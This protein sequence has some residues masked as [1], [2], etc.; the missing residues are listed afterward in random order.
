MNY[1][2]H[3]ALACLLVSLS[4]VTFAQS[5]SV[6]RITVYGSYNAGTHDNP[7]E[8]CRRE[9]SVPNPYVT[10]ANGRPTLLPTPGCYFDETYVPTGVV[11]YDVFRPILIVSQV[12]PFAYGTYSDYTVS[13]ARL[14]CG[15]ADGIVA[16]KPVSCPVKAGNPILCNNGAKLEPTYDD[17]SNAVRLKRNFS[18]IDAF[19]GQTISNIIGNGWHSDLTRKIIITAG[20]GVLGAS[21]MVIRND[22]T[23][24]F[25]A[26]QGNGQ[27]LP[28]ADMVRY[29]LEE[30]QLN[31]LASYVLTSLDNHQEFYDAA[32]HIYQDVQDG[33][34]MVSYQRDS[35]GRVTS[36]QDRN[37]RIATVSY[38]TSGLVDKITLPDGQLI[39]YDYDSSNRLITVTKSGDV[40]TYSYATVSGGSATYLSGVTHNGVPYSMFTYDAQ[41]RANST[42]HAGG[43]DHYDV[44]YSSDGNTATVTTPTGATK[45]LQFNV[46][47]G[48][49][50]PNAWQIAGSG[51]LTSGI[52]FAYNANSNPISQKGDQLLT[53]NYYDASGRYKVATYEFAVAVVATC[54]TTQTAAAAS[55]FLR[56]N[57]TQWDS[58]VNVPTE[59]K[60]F[61]TGNVL[62]ARS[63]FIYNSR[64]Q[65]TAACQID[66]NNTTAMAY[67]CGSTPNA[68]AGVRQSITTYC[69]AA[70]VT[71]GTCP[72]VGLPIANNGPRI[73]VSDIS[74]FNYYQ[75]DD[76]TCATPPATCLYR[77]G[78]LWKVTNALNQTTEYLKY[79][80]AGR[81]LQ[82]KDANSVITDMEYHPRGWLKA[83]KVRGSDNASE[84]DD[85]ITRL[86]YDLSG[87]V[88]KVT[89][90]DLEFINLTYDAAHRLTSISDAWNNSITYSLDNAGKRIAETAA[91]P[92][93]IITLS[94]SNL[95]DSLGRLKSNKNAAGDILSTL[96]YDANDNLNTRMDSLGRVADQDVDPLNRLKKI[97][98]DQGAGK[99]NA[100]TQLFYDARDNLTKVTDPKSLNTTYTYDGLNNLT[101]L[102]SPDT[103][104]TIYTYDEAGNRKTQ[105]DAKLV[106]TNYSYDSL[107]RL[108]QVSYPSSSGLT[109]TF[110]YDTVNPICGATE[111]FAKGR[112]TKFT[113][114][115]GNTQYCFDRFGNIT[116][117]QVTNNSLVS[118]FVY[119]YTLGGRL[120]SLTYP[121]GMKVSYSRN[122]LGQVSQVLVTYGTVTKVFAN[123]ITYYPFGPLSKIEFVPPGG[124]GGT[125]LISGGAF[126]MSGA[127]TPSVGGGGC[128]P[129]GCTPVNPVV[130]TRVY[131]LDYAVQSIGGLQYTV[132]SQGSITQIGDPS[133]N[134]YEYDN[135][136]RLTGVINTDTQAYV[137]QFAY[138]PTGNRSLKKAGAATAVTNTY[139]STSHQL[140]SVGANQRSYDLVGNAILINTGTNSTTKRFTYDA[141][142]RMVN[143]K[144]GALATIKAEYQYNAKGERVR[145]Y[146]G[147]TDKARYQYNENG[148]LLVEDKVISGVTTTQEI[149]WLD[150]MPI[151][152]SQ[153][154]TLHGVLTDHLNS[155]RAIFEVGTQK[156]V[157]RWNLV[158]DAFGENFAIEDADVDGN[159][160]IFDLR[161]PGQL[162][163]AESALH[164][165]YFRDYDAAVGRYVESDPIGLR[166]GI[167]TFGYGKQNPTKYIDSDGRFA[168]APIFGCTIAGA[169]VGGLVSGGLSA[170]TERNWRQD[171]TTGAIGGAAGGLV[172]C[173]GGPILGGIVG[174]V[175]EKYV[176]EELGYR[177]RACNYQQDYLEAAVLGGVLGWVFSGSASNA[178][179]G[180]VESVSG[181]A[182]GA[183]ADELKGF[184][185]MFFPIDSGECQCEQQ[186]K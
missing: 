8:V 20:D 167:S 66:P 175:T 83:R 103:S 65:A 35:S 71:A 13:P 120:S 81:V 159:N 114:P 169:V 21:A 50:I 174:A 107:N 182:A 109:S 22:G 124:T 87:N 23:T 161:F 34:L 122:N 164:Y 152:V 136:D 179:E 80:G 102:S 177:K 98:Q 18:S 96:T 138:D 27:W 61:N 2:K 172:T 90:P 57:T 24:M 1:V 16:N 10:R 131:D 43:V 47:S 91:D 143:F 48:T 137:T 92:N 128:P 17:L 168:L 33:Q 133:G 153:N 108:T 112:L 19:P 73:D 5:H 101:Q 156:T 125:T 51:V 178:V 70:G 127:A 162:Y 7:Q 158:D 150:D 123:N 86:E 75:T 59:R 94:L 146:L 37:G 135:L 165:N 84:S 38:L 110:I 42:E 181:S 67:L 180:L 58:L 26:K 139:A 126:S 36:I 166:G 46:A 155:P 184:K 160:F 111:N 74:T 121:S 32:G 147:A 170:I 29:R 134:A 141:R 89:L 176:A 99:I 78:D 100:T 11:T 171:A 119:S 55:T 145:K 148:Q 106:F 149:I 54:P 41:A 14:Y 144:E 186:K 72:I 60:T 113:D 116:R 118:T 25:F 9:E 88:T 45:T 185:E 62:E 117:K 63:V 132:N 49:R 39:D 129:G 105:K 12:C 173:L 3:L 53:C 93:S 56:G 77:K 157:W 142:N 130:Q 44:V 97:V 104:T 52:N 31:G 154:N 4:S 40:T 183:A 69:E 163:D 95:F 85:A 28:E 76:A 30:V 79:D 140:T 82:M 68:P 6:P 151:G 64:G 15:R 115:S